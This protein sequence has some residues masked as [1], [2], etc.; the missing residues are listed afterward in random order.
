[1]KGQATAA[2][3]IR[4]SQV[5]K[6]RAFGCECGAKHRLQMTWHT[7]IIVKECFHIQHGIVIEHCVMRNKEG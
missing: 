3:K 6:D 7:V 4:P 5:M 2:D 1:M